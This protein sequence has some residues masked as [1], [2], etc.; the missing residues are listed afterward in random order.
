MG[1]AVGSTWLPQGGWVRWVGGET[2]VRWP[3]CGGG[4]GG[5]WLDRENGSG[6][7]E[8]GEGCMVFCG[9]C[10]HGNGG[11]GDCWASIWWCS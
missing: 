6:R 11:C 5:G 7:V 10:G 8:D 3:C 4:A 9:V 1:D 2:R